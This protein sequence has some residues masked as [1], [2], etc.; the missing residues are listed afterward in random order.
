MR[1]VFF[2][3]DDFA[4]AHLSRLISD[5]HTCAALVTQPDKPKGRGLQVTLSATKVLAQG[6]GIQ[7]FQP[8]DLKDPRVLAQ[9]KCYEADVF[10]VVAYGRF[11][12]DDVLKI[13]RFY[14][15]NVHPSL[16]PRYRGAAPINWAVINGEAETGVT[17]IRMN[18]AMDGGDILAQ[19]RFALPQDM[20]SLELRQNLMALGTDMLS[21]ILPRVVTGDIVLQR[22]DSACATRAPKMHKELG[23][24]HWESPAQAIHNLVRGT[25]P[26]P[27]A[28]TFLN[29][30]MI[31]VLEAS[32]AVSAFDGRPGEIIEKRQDGFC[33]QAGDGAIL[34]RRVLPAGGKPM[35]ARSFMA[36]HRVNCGDQLRHKDQ[37]GVLG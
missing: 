17:L 24:I 16:L 5:G 7:V 10:V 13:P 23:I 22:Q 3:C 31:K 6:A 35:D 9:L 2:G 25:Q 27:G 33:V 30:V 28:Y 34:V 12:P 11:L 14:C 32:A 37:Q 20:T 19:E 1:I 36:G 4:A 8:E 26:W 18:A 29:G 15:V 21:G